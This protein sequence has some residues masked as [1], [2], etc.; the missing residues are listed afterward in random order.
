MDLFQAPLT[1]ETEEIQTS[2]L[3]L[4]PIYVFMLPS[5]RKYLWLHIT[6]G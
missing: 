3:L 6:V 5:L 2:L 4:A 1:L